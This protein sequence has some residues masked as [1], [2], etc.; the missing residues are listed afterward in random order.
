M[1]VRYVDDSHRSR[2]SGMRL[3]VSLG[4]ASLAVWVLGPLVKAGGFRMLL[5]VMAATAACTLVAVLFLPRPAARGGLT[6][7]AP[8][9]SPRAA[10]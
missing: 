9:E 2:V 6:P 8:R 1:I 10:G 4:V 5:F 7:G 3:T